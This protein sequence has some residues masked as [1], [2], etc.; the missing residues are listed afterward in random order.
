MVGALLG[1]RREAKAWESE[2]RS[3]HASA[4][5]PSPLLQIFRRSCANQ[6]YHT[7]WIQPDIRMLQACRLCSR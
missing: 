4:P 1:A 5:P 6:V 7:I 3:V 2:L